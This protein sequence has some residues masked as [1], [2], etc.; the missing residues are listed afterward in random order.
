[1]RVNLLNLVL[2]IQVNSSLRQNYFLPKKIG[3]NQKQV[4]VAGI[5]IYF[6]ELEKKSLTLLNYLFGIKMYLELG[7]LYYLS[8]LI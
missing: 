6:L 3:K 4:I 8:P 1:M 5:S 2:C 7:L